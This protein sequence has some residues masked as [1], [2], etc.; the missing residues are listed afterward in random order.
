[1]F[2]VYYATD[3]GGVKRFIGSGFKY[4]ALIPY[5]MVYLAIKSLIHKTNTVDIKPYEL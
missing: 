5:V 3:F 4:V 2:M 1:M